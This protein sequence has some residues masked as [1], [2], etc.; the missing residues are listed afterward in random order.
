M[1][2]KTPITLCESN[3]GL[4]EVERIFNAINYGGVV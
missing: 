2:G 4:L 3:A 1:L